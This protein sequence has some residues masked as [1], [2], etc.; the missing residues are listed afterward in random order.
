MI[1]GFNSFFEY[2][3]FALAQGFLDQ[4]TNALSTYPKSSL[5]R[6]GDVLVRPV[7]GGLNLSVKNIHN[8]AVI[9]GLALMAIAAAT[10]FFYPHR[11]VIPFNLF[12]AGRVKFALYCTIMTTIFGLSLRTLGRLQEDGELF[13]QWQMRDRTGR[14]YLQPIPIGATLIH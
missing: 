14:R 8:P 1:T 9:S 13:V 12:S 5:E 2:S 6:I 4:R 7:L 10:V 3:R 11:I